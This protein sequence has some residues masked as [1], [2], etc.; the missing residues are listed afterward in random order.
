MHGRSPTG[1]GPNQDSHVRVFD[2]TIKDQ[3]QRLAALLG[4]AGPFTLVVRPDG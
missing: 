1:I 2:L 3:E 4:V